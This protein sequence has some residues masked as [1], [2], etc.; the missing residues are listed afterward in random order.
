MTLI[1]FNQNFKLKLNLSEFKKVRPNSMYTKIKT[2]TQI[3]L[4]L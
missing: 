1:F 4:N 3:N 2:I